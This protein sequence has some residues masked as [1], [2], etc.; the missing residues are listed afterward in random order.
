MPVRGS[1]HCKSFEFEVTSVPTSLLSCNC[2]FCS[3]FGALWGYYPPEQF[4]LIAAPDV[5]PTYQWG[6]KIIKHHFC[7]TCGCGTY[8]ESLDWETGDPRISINARLLDD[9]DVASIPI[10]EVDGRNLW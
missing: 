4:R 2:S 10:E 5:I 9:I 3:K 8:T 1:C 7:G 6:G